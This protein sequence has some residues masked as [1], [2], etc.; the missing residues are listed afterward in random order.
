[1]PSR[2]LKNSARLANPDRMLQKLT[3]TL[4]WV[5]LTLSAGLA[6]GCGYHVAGQATRIPS[7]V[8]T[9]AIP[10][11]VNNT[12]RFRIEQI[13]TAA[14]SR[15]FIERTRFQISHEIKGADA[16]LEGSVRSVTAAAVTFD[17]NTGRATAFQITVLA[18]IKLTD[19]HT[20]KVLFSNPNYVF[21]EEYQVSQSTSTLFEEDRP[22]L[23]R[24]A[25]DLAR[26]L[27]TD[28]LENF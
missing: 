27:V 25:Q 15:E 6:V 12:P 8:Q 21:R 20:H 4:L 5:I 17:P 13:L 19:L 18:S 10:M 9:I 7:D 28:I 11:F 3:T 14:V 1:M 22:A 16:L 23:N 24:L 2:S 26:T